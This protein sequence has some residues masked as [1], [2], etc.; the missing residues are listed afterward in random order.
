MKRAVFF[1]PCLLFAQDFSQRGF[2]ET[3]AVLYPQTTANDASHAVGEGQFRY[4]AFYKAAPNL[5]F[6]GGI[7]LRGDT[8]NETERAFG[9]SWWDRERQRPA[10]AVRRFSAT[11]TRGKLTIEAGKQFI[12]WGKADILNPTDRFAPRDFVN[13]VDNDFLG[14]TAARVSYG[15]QANTIE[16]VFSPRLTPS[17]IPLLNQRWAALP[18]GIPIGELA[19][20]FPGGTQFG[21]RWNHIGGVAE[22]SLSFYNGYDHLPLFRAVPEPASLGLERFYP[23]MRM[24]GGD[25]AVPFAVLT[26]K[27]EAAYFT[28]GTPQADQYLLWVLQLERQAGE[29]SFTGGYAGQAITAHG[30]AASFSPERGFTRA[31]VARAGYIIDVNRSVAFETVIRQNGRGIYVKP[32]YTQAVG[33]HWRITA[34]F[35]LIRGASSDFLGQYRRNSHGILGLRYSF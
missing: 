17:R 28:S 10:F 32:E 25:A 6:A 30:T 7:D 22:Y 9:L 5:R 29:W 16:L 31:L 34:G 21:G 27:A 35:A 1:L 8:H 15:T 26:V 14:I 19:P 13:V 24:Y 4:E 2:L 11:Y 12:R 23:Q 33:Q 3:T 18:A 20:D